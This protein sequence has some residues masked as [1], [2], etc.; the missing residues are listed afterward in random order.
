MLASLLMSP[1]FVL[2]KDVW[3]LTQ[4]AAVASRRAI[5]LATRLPREMGKQNCTREVCLYFPHRHPLKMPKQENFGSDTT[6]VS[7]SGSVMYTTEMKI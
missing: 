3:I 6:T 1:I 5:N 4:R 7:L 2:L